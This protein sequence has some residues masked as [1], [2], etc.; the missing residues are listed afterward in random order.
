M[1]ERLVVRE[2]Y[3]LRCAVPMCQRYLFVLYAY[4]EVARPILSQPRRTR[5]P[6]KAG[7]NP[8]KRVPLSVVSACVPSQS[9]HP[10]TMRQPGE[11]DQLLFKTTDHPV[12]GS[13]ACG[14][15]TEG[16]RWSSTCVQYAAVLSCAGC[17]QRWAAVCD[18]L[19]QDS[20]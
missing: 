17:L 1:N 3:S 10:G 19:S 4:C 14:I 20:A 5:L 16:H 7:A 9:S 12:R 18:E 13:P 11:G 6:R 8:G 15:V 2:S